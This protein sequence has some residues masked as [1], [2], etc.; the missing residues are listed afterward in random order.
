M[1]AKPVIVARFS[2]SRG[3]GTHDV[4]F[5]LKLLLKALALGFDLKYLLVDKAYPSEN[6]IAELWRRGIRAVIPVKKRWATTKQ[7]F[8]EACKGL[9][10]W[11]DRNEN[12]DFHEVYRLRPKIES[13]FSLL[14]R[15]ADGFCWSRG[16]RDKKSNSDEPCVAWMNEMLCK[17]IYTNLRITVDQEMDTG[18]KVNYLVRDNVLPPI[19]DKDRLLTAA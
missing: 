13:L 18:Y 16:R 5:L 2:G 15:M 7:V 14:K 17:L 1:P 4:N 6:V 9:V 19:P 10:Q 8:Y 12:R 11:F 3:K